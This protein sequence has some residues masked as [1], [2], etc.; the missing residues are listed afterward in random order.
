M[1]FEKFGD[2]VREDETIAEAVEA[3]YWDRVIDYVNRVCL[4]QARGIL[5]PRKAAKSR[6]RGSPPDPAR[7]P[8]EGLRPHP[9]FFK[10]KDE[11]LEEEF[12]KF[13][14]DTKPDAAEAIPAIKNRALRSIA[15]TPARLRENLGTLG[16]HL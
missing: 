8:G 9:A 4:R 14:A 5:H 13:V 12:A 7:D 16:V 3:G 6:S 2:A 1:F 15:E 11:L 10:S